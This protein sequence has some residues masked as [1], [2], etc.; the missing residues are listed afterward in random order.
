MPT[1]SFK[2]NKT[3]SMSVAD[4]NLT[5]ARSGE[6]VLGVE[7][8]S[9]TKKIAVTQAGRTFD[10]I[11]STLNFTAKPSSQTFTITTDGSWY[12]EASE[13]W[14]GLS[15]TTGKGASDI[16]VSVKE[17]MS[18]TERSARIIVG[19]G[20]T[21]QTLLVV[22]N[23][24]YMTITP[25]SLTALGSTGG[26]RIVQIASN[27]QWTASKKASWLTITPANGMGDID[28]TMTAADNPSVNPR[29]D[30]VVIVPQYGQGVKI[31]VLQNARYLNVSTSEINFFYKGGESEPVVVETDGSYKI[32]TTDSW[33]TIKDNGKSFTVTATK[34]TDADMRN[35]MVV[36]E[37]TDLAGNES[38]KIEVIVLQYP[39][40]DCTLIDGFSDDEDWNQYIYSK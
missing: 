21:K 6:V 23:G 1:E 8:V 28:M 11:V 5:T 29:R 3:L 14:V 30:T 9:L 34:N 22:Q 40:I 37:L 19:V 35:G 7:G 38:M 13:E 32:S 10:D 33:L 2:G 39:G 4:Y 17:N 12:A 24:Y 20:E 36:A 18:D 16:T 31:V 27:G 25:T 15:K 26:S